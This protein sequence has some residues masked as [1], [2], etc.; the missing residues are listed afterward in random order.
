[1]TETL[2]LASGA[3][4]PKVG[5]GFWKIDSEAVPSIV[6]EAIDVGYRH[7]D[8]A[9]DYG[10][11]EAVG[12][13]LSASLNSGRC[14]RE[15]LWVTSKLWNTYHAPEHVRP[16]LQKTLTDLQL[17]ELDL[18][19]IHF[20]ISLKYV[21]FEERYPPGW[22]FDPEQETPQMEF[23]PVP[24]LE[25]WQAM[26][27]LV[28]EGLIKNIG[29][30]NFNT[31]LLADLLN[32]ARIRPS[33]L[34][35][36]R[37]PYLVQEK[38]LKYCQQQKI[39]VTGFS[40]LGALSYVPIGMAGTDDSVLSQAVVQDIAKRHGRT[41]AQVVLRWGVQCE[42][43][44]IPKTTR[45]ERLVENISIFDFELSDDEMAAISGLDQHRRF[46]DP[47]DFGLEAFN[48]FCPIYD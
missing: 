36:E 9:C 14:Q 39:A 43:A 10:N 13:G 34:Q 28:D 18:Y 40:P 38:L 44:V 3:K 37:H 42:T 46:N 27:E 7:F 47:G 48:T 35:I 21:P 17:D 33:V 2:Q 19:L 4:L 11:E 29:V 45:R 8:C 25:T 31:G 26:E 30:C 23:A 22:V 41:P 5:L 6:E 12:R 15:D 20:P 1:M 24:I 16:A 32:G